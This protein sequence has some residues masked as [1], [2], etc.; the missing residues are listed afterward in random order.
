MENTQMCYY[1]AAA[2]GFV[3][4]VLVTCIACRLRGRCACGGDKGGK[5][6][7][8]RKPAKRV[9]GEKFEKRHPAPAD[10][11]IEIYV[12]NL[13]YDLTEDQLRKEF[14]AYGTVNSAR[15]ITNR[16][17]GRSVRPGAR[18][19]QV[20]YPVDLYPEEDW[21]WDMVEACIPHEFKTEIGKEIWTDSTPAVRLPEGKRLV[22]W[23]LSWIGPD[24]RILRDCELGNLRFDADGWYTSGSKELDA[25]VQD[26]LNR[27]LVEGMDE[28]E[29]LLTL[30]RYVRDNFKYVRRAPYEAGETPWVL[31][32]ATDMLA[33]GKGNCYSYASTYCML[34]RAIGVDAI[35]ISGHV[36]SNFA[37][38][39][40]VE[41]ERNGEPH[42]FDTELSMAHPEQGDLYYYDRSYAA[43][44]N[45]SYVKR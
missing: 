32:E 35:V 28:E 27:V 20:G 15:I 36:G 19:L 16:A 24:G 6:D 40:W 26:T 3:A 7:A 23:R 2:I 25:L 33:T 8:P 4:G 39:G 13:S 29:Q 17:T 10:G 11:S 42:I 45:W 44:A 41:I 22:G 31:D 12:G 14:E 1:I 5:K 21:Y 37:P 43:I 9:D 30:Y 34:V 18:L 38:H